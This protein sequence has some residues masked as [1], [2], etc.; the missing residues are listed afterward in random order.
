MKI[1]FLTEMGFTGKI[2]V[3]HTN[4]RT[5]FA[6]MHA[7]NAC[8]YNIR[9]FNQIISYDVVFII[10]PKGKTY[11]SAD[12]STL[13]NNMNPISDLL[14][15]DIVSKLK[16]NNNKVFFIQEGPS[17]WFNDY[18]LVDQINF[19]NM[20]READGLFAHNIHD[21]LFWKG[22]L[23][24]DKVH[25]IPTL[26]LTD[27]IPDVKWNPQ[28]K[29][30]IGGNFSRWYGGMQSYIVAQEFGVEMWTMTSHSKRAYE[31]QIVNHLPRVMWSDWMRQLSEFK[32]A[33][34]LMPTAAAGT[35]SLNCAYLGIPCIGNEKMDTQRLCH[36]HLSV[37]VDNV[38]HAK[39]LAKKLATDSDFYLEMSNIAK[40]NYQQHYDITVWKNKIGL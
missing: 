23:D 40:I 22:Y 3:D 9:N 28:D 35:F 27:H 37:D 4:M 21:T 6:W 38:A 17:W 16:Q 39:D 14:T 7:L 15:S 36:P 25:V 19:I 29:A 24:I 13:S 20:I 33:V 1:A 11:L 30:I 31:D 26:M 5:E 34:H 18:E 8:H 10:F 2:P 12:G 32:Y